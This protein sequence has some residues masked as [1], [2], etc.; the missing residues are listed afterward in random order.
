[1]KWL[2]RPALAVLGWA[3]AG[4][5]AAVLFSG[6]AHAD[7]LPA[8]SDQG[9]SAPYYIVTDSYN[10]EPEYL[11]EIAERFLGNGDR[12][13][14]IFELN[15]GRWE[16]G[17]QQVANP[18]VIE[19]GWVLR[20]PADA[21]GKEVKTGV[22]PFHP[23]PAA[24]SASS[25]PAATAPAA[26]TAAT[27]PPAAAP[28]GT[29]G[30]SSWLIIVAG[31]LGVALLAAGAWFGLLVLRRKRA[32]TAIV[33]P[34]VMNDSDAWT[35]DRAAR[36][37]ATACV[38]QGREAPE[39]VA[40]VLGPETVTLRLATPDEAAP[41]GWTV[42]DD[43]RTW[44]ATVSEV[45]RATVDNALPEPFPRLVPLGLTES[46]QV[47]L[48]L[49]QSGGVISLDG[50]RDR[51][52]DLAR[53]WSVRLTRSPWAAN[54]RVIRVGFDHE[55]GERFTGVDATTVTD[56]ARVAETSPG[57]VLLLAGT[58]R[59]HDL[60]LVNALLQHPQRV[61]SAVVIQ[62]DEAQ[63]RLSIAATGAVETSLVPKLAGLRV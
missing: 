59:G 52:H 24:S 18:E 43:G 40:L 54:I 50:D 21:K 4:L 56:A 15:K 49:A 2:G 1:M 28:A 46:G 14:E 62:A 39:T 23:E 63:W 31:V 8:P 51:A 27:T 25:A 58:P 45:Q 11:Y 7:P 20:L 29:S 19:P 47:L 60:A 48:N 33:P 9:Q 22:L 61:W 42:G 17:G 44:S 10:G 30:G 37:L 26:T 6:A 32:K 35:V 3:M 57:G 13:M 5:T 55:A 38:Q 34:P 16:P 12:A 53:A 36:A 41:I